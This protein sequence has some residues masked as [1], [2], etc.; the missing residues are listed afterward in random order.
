MGN[1]QL[2]LN[3]LRLDSGH[4]GKH[5]QKTRKAP[6]P[7]VKA[8]KGGKNKKNSKGKGTVEKGSGKGEGKGKA[9]EREGKGRGQGKVSS[10]TFTKSM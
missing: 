9:G 2:R 8:V 1:G 7:R 3:N 5:D 10:S 6:S 4:D